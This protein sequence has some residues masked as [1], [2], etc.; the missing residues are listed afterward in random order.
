MAKTG[1]DGNI[2]ERNDLAAGS[3]RSGSI[4]NL[5]NG[6]VVKKSAPTPENPL[7]RASAHRLPD[8]RALAGSQAALRGNKHL[9]FVIG[10]PVERCSK[11]LDVEV[12]VHLTPFD[13]GPEVVVEHGQATASAAVERDDPDVQGTLSAA[14]KGRTSAEFVDRGFLKVPGHTLLEPIEHEH[15]VAT[16][17]VKA[18]GDRETAYFTTIASHTAYVK[19]KINIAAGNDEFPRPPRVTEVQSQLDIEKDRR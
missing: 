13:C 16:P 12:D 3:E 10:D 4:R 15:A 7:Q 2:V 19:V 14:G 6:T 18:R 8:D 1:G 17:L 9:K 5:S 11:D